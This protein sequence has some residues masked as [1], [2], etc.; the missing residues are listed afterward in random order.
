MAYGLKQDDLE[1]IKQVFAAHP[2]VKEVILF[3][4]RAMGS[5]DTGSD[6]DL[7]IA[8]NDLALTDILDLSH[9]LER[10]DMLYS[11]DV[12]ALDSITDKEVLAHI[13]RV[14][15]TIYALR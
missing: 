5:Y 3:G 9:D 13:H 7:A 11:F 15:K 4:S 10:L 8:G 12:Q 14:G 6:I 1:R 2:K